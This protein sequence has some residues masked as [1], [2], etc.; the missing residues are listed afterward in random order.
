MGAIVG[1]LI[2]FAILQVMDIRAV[3][4]FSLIPAPLQ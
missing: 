2:A 1:P 4:L 3:F